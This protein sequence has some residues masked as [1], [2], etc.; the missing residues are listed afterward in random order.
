MSTVHANSPRDALF[1]VESMVMMATATLPLRAIRMNMASALN[2]I[3]H[4]ERMRDGI[5]RIQNVVEVAGIEG[6]T[7]TLRELFAFRYHG[8]RRD[9]TIEGAFE[10]SRM[11]PD[12]TNRAAFYGL[13]KELLGALGIRGG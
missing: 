10:S 7:I 13:D 3:V 6:E 4:I 8:E 5:R 1:R 12:F 2:L 9:G 11:R